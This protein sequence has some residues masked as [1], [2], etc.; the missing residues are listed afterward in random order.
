MLSFYYLE[1][2]LFQ[3]YQTLIQFYPLTGTYYTHV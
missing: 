3:K 2:G 1:F